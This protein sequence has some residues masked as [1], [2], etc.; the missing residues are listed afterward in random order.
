M[1][2][3]VLSEGTRVRFSMY[4]EKVYFLL[5]VNF[6]GNLRESLVKI[7]GDLEI[8]VDFWRLMNINKYKGRSVGISGD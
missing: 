7:S 2:C 8:S 3:I 5:L 6:L 1:V 4:Q